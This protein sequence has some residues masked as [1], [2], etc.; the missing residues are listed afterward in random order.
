MVDD[1]LWAACRQATVLEIGLVEQ[2]LG[3]PLR[4][5]RHGHRRGIG[6]TARPDHASSSGGAA[7]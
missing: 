7:G 6:D 5:D 2:R 1:R 4:Y 3:F